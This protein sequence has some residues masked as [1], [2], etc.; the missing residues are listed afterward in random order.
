MKKLIIG[1][2]IAAA[3]AALIAIG[4][5]ASHFGL[6]FASNI[7][8][9]GAVGDFFGGV[10]N[11]TFALL[12]LILIAYTLMQ[13][14]KAL[15]QSELAI[16]QGTKAIEQNEK[17]LQVSNRELELTR[18]ELANSSKAL[19]EQASLLAV[20][21][22]ETTFFNMLELHIK[23][24]N[25]IKLSTS[26]INQTICDKFELGLTL[27]KT[28]Y[29][30]GVTAIK[31]LIQIIDNPPVDSLKNKNAQIAQSLSTFSHIYPNHGH[32]IST[33]FIHFYQMLKLIDDAQFS[34]KYKKNYSN[35]LRAQ[36]TNQ[37]FSLLI[38]NCLCPSMDNGKLRE[39]VIE[40]EIL[41]HLDICYL[42]ELN[43]FRVNNP[44]I[45]F[46]IDNI[47]RFIKLDVNNKLIKSAFGKNRK[48]HEYFERKHFLRD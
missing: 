21:S 24:L 13:N 29:F 22:F 37:E 14:K 8:N 31:L 48:M 20:Q 25:R 5:F 34:Y 27:N 35:I 41:E 11:P 30:E 46:T 32:L 36:F 1:I 3:I 26:E 47:K 12:S 15:E 38:L 28:E 33:Y 17:A 42:E 4:A 23:N 16:E 19:E 40:F 39:L 45:D 10:L 18:N 7:G 9:W 43:R 6:G 2:C 44:K